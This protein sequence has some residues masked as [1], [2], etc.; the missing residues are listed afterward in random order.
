VHTKFVPDEAVLPHI[1][2]AYVRAVV[3]RSLNR[4]QVAALDLVQFH[5]CVFVP[6]LFGGLDW[7]GVKTEQ[8]RKWAH[9][10]LSENVENL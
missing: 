6:F 8:K 5:W 4:L 2:D 3:Q 10:L 7:I 9:S 1:D